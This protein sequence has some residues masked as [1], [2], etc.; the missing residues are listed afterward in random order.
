MGVESGDGSKNNG[1]HG[2][3]SRIIFRVPK[4][5]SGDFG[6]LDLRWDWNVIVAPNYVICMTAR[7]GSTVLTDQLK[8]TRKLGEPYEF[9]N[10]RKMLPKQLRKCG[11]STFEEY[12][13]YIR[14][15][16]STQNGCFGMKICFWDFFAFIETGLF[17]KFFNGTKFVYLRRD[18]IV[19]Q[20][21]SLYIASEG[22]VWHK[23]RNGTFL[24]LA[25]NKDVV[26][27][28][29]R[30]SEKIAWLSLE[31]ARWRTFFSLA[32]IEPLDLAYEEVVESIPRAVE[33]VA[34][35]VG[36]EVNIDKLPE[37][38]YVRMSSP[39]NEAFIERFRREFENG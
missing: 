21:V 15:R 23:R 39:L 27:D 31:E 14:N 9:F 13:Q 20:A 16:F 1:R 34:R 37:P 30:I 26:Y 35:F 32:H 10:T 8:E 28:S 38:P 36:E 6:G 33:K 24:G 3:T 4:G 7:S 25:S 2:E 29:A 19:A 11:A 17:R 22:G 18:D 12:W 5:L